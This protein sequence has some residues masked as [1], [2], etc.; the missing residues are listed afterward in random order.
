MALRETPYHEV[1]LT[2]GFLM[3]K[4]PI[5][6][7][8]YRAVMG[9]NPSF[10]QGVY[11]IKEVNILE[12][13]DTDNLPVERVSWYNAVEFCNRLSRAKGLYPAYTIDKNTQDLNNTSDN[14]DDP[15]WT[16][17]LDI[18]ANGYRLPTEAEWEYA[19]RAGTTTPFS[20]GLDEDGN[21]VDGTDITL[22]QANFD[23][24]P[25]SY[26]TTPGTPLYRTSEV[27][28][29]QPNKWGLYDMHGNV[30]E[31]CWDRIN[32]DAPAAIYEN[33]YSDKYKPQNTINPTGLLLANRRAERG[34][35][36]NHPAFRIRSAWR[37]RCDAAMTRHEDLGFRVVRTIITEGP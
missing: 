18:R 14:R 12:E 37:E 34:G 17:T 6:Q 24:T 10:F 5:T 15:K 13:V 16:V 35:S 9:I 33:F 27:G 22:E 32:N 36:Y 28:S 31:W 1:E 11:K 25:Y 7:A 30:Y 20:L 4:Y 19:C 2:N 21:D 3:G 26:G 8:Q 29:Y 23:G